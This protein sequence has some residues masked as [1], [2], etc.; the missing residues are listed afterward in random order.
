MARPANHDLNR[1]ALHITLQ[2]IAGS[3]ADGFWR[4]FSIARA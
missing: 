4:S 3:V 2:Q 1:L